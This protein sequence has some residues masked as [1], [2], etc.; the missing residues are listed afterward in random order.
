M[1]KAK[2]RAIF[3]GCL[4][5]CGATNATAQNGQAGGYEVDVLIDVSGSMKRNDPGNKR[6]SAVKLL[7]NL[8][9]DGTRAAIWLFA[10]NTHLLLKT[11]AVDKQW[12][13]RALVL[14]DKIHSR[15]LL[16]DIE[17]AIQTVLRE[18][19]APGSSNNLILLT[20][21]RVDISDDIMQSAESR[22]RVISDLI[23]VLQRQRIKVHT[24]ALS[25]Q[26]DR[27]LLDKLSFG[28]GGWAEALESAEQLQK[29]LLTMFN[30]ALPQDTVPIKDN[31]FLID[32][33]VKE[34]SLL[35]FKKAGAAPTRLI[36]PNGE[37]LSRQTRRKN[38]PGFMINI[39][40]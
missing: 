38:C 24:I 5:L 18:D 22:Q 10:Q 12:K 3:L 17:G 34:F 35:V 16:T 19:I 1:I 30:K 23:P 40:T 8:L 25:D 9:P 14:A 37:K 4:L 32:D 11:A 6:I 36:G 31:R 20:D 29:T 21:G 26:A 2:A 27:E 7:I 28:T 39:M 15:G 13:Q 33:A